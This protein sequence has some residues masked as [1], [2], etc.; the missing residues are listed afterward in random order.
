MRQMKTMKKHTSDSNKITMGPIETIE[1][2]QALH[3]DDPVSID[4]TVEVS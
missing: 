3:S 2:E 1:T 4:A